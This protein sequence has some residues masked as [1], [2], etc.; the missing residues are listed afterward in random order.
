LIAA[1]E[2]SVDV[3]SIANTESTSITVAFCLGFELIPSE[4]IPVR[5]RVKRTRNLS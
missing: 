5:T 1:F 3:A 2:G 4:R